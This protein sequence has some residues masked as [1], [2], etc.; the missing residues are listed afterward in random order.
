MSESTP[1]AKAGMAELTFAQVKEQVRIKLRDAEAD[2][3]TASYTACP[4]E[5][6]I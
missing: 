2:H 1:N 5:R 4:F 6:I 3:K